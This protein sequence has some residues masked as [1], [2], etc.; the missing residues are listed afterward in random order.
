[1]E[2]QFLISKEN[3][4]TKE[5]VILKIC[6]YDS[7]IMI[8][9]NFVNNE[10]YYY[11]YIGTFE[12]LCV[13]NNINSNFT[14]SCF[15]DAC[16][17]MNY[18]DMIENSVILKFP[19]YVL[20]RNFI[21]LCHKKNFNKIEVYD[22][23]W[24]SSPYLKPSELL[25]S[26]QSNS[27]YLKWSELSFEGK[28][29][30][31]SEKI[32]TIET[33]V[34]LLT[35]KNKLAHRLNPINEGVIP[36]SNSHLCNTSYKT[37]MEG[38]TTSF[39]KACCSTEFQPV[40]KP[41]NNSIKITI[42][43]NKPIVFEDHIISIK[44]KIKCKHYTH[45]FIFPDSLKYL[46]FNGGSYNIPIIL[47]ANLIKCKIFNLSKYNYP[48]IFPVSISEICLSR[49]NNFNYPLMFPPHSYK[50]AVAG[51]NINLLKS[52]TL[53]VLRKFNHPII[54]PDSVEY[55]N[56][57]NLDKFNSEIN[58]STSTKILNL[59]GMK[60]FNKQL[61]INYEIED[62]NIFKLRKLTECINIHP[63]TCFSLK[64][65]SFRDL[66]VYNLPI[67]IP[68]STE[69]VNISNL[70]K[71]NS[72]LKLPESI[73]TFNFEKSPNFNF[74]INFPARVV[75]VHLSNLD[76][77]N[78][79]LVFPDLHILGGGGCGDPPPPPLKTLN[80]TKMKEFNHSINLP[81]TL[82][83]LHISDLNKFDSYL[84]FSEN[85]SLKYL[86]LSKLPRF[87]HPIN[88]CES[89]EEFNLCNMKVFNSPII[90]SE[91]PTASLKTLKLNELEE[92]NYPL[93]IPNTVININ[94][95]YLYQITSIILSESIKD[96][97]IY[98]IGGR[99]NINNKPF[100]RYLFQ[101]KNVINCLIRCIDEIGNIEFSSLKEK[102]IRYFLK[103]NH[104]N[105]LTFI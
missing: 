34:N 61:S 98:G 5:N 15:I 4:K 94:L 64:T 45:K 3:I 92:F 105:K 100:I 43:E 56:I 59:G 18:L 50:V 82:E 57:T 79:P 86:K 55:V 104:S 72:E 36:F 44:I 97:K 13:S 6:Y 70:N 66:A 87:N 23:K 22:F 75:E 16:K 7:M 26:V 11:S 48:L 81:R 99:R 96:C 24:S 95:S 102:Y 58:L 25:D 14:F 78:L 33:S 85:I 46:S 62:I 1:M 28:L 35:N 42:N 67:I 39:V 38:R 76:K 74:P 83:K 9:L 19:L 77:F 41:V 90:F 84:E 89:L 10:N 65:F 93:V 103:N 60:E 53:N 71:F 31:L 20:N 63:Y 17:N 51:T 68:G 54:I 32:A 73:K 69:Y 91:S 101:N 88:I 12:S 30:K 49:L 47:P 21:I 8:S 52:L 2:Y 29:L 40:K 37:F 27:D 80:L